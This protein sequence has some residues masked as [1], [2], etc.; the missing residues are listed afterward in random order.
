MRCVISCIANKFQ[1]VAL[2][3]YLKSEKYLID[4]Y[5]DVLQV[6]GKSSGKEIFLF[7]YGAVAMWGLTRREEEEF[8]Q[9]V[10]PYTEQLL[11]VVERRHFSFR[12]G[13][14]TRMFFHKRFPV[15]M[16]TLANH[17]VEL[18]LALSYGL[19]QS[20]KL[21]YYEAKVQRIIQENTPLFENLAQ[22]GKI[23]L[24]RKEINKRMGEIF[25]T[26]SLVNLNSEYL[27]LPE[28]F[29]EHPHLENDYLISVHF[30]DIQQRVA[31]LNQ[32]LDV[33]N[34]LFNMLNGQ[35][36]HQHSSFLEIIII[37]IIGVETVL[38]I[39][40]ILMR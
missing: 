10:R 16:I 24:S 19:G 17:E 36:Q 25:L 23:L 1:L 14:K 6:K 29:W 32:Q 22:T 4:L 21:E 26:R 18:K 7:A 33:L 31:T 27:D 39:L 5:R 8:L 11:S 20:V 35:Q 15:E 12:Y 2:A 40:Q 3:D 30:L 13:N 38:S 9:I 34:E 28:Y 37:A